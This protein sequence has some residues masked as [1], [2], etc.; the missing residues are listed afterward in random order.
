MDEELLA[1]VDEEGNW[2][3]KA[4][5]LKSVITNNAYFR[6]NAGILSLEQINELLASYPGNLFFYGKDGHFLYYKQLVDMHYD[7]V[8]LGHKTIDSDIFATLKS[9][10]KKRII[11]PDQT[12]SLTRFVIDEY[13]SVYNKDHQFSGVVETVQD[14]YPLVEYYLQKTGQKLV[15]DPDS[16]NGKLYRKNAETD[17][18]TGAS[19]WEG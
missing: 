8:E 9:G 10:S 17:A 5:R 12:N 19:E 14:I 2:L 15:I 6:L 1:L 16:N 11:V 13:K 3:K 4:S 18:E 7:P